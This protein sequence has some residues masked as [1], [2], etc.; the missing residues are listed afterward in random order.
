MRMCQLIVYVINSD[1]AISYNIE[2]KKVLLLLKIAWFER[3]TK[4]VIR[5]HNAHSLWYISRN[6]TYTYR[7]WIYK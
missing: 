7:A 2:N 1:S 3:R 4:D 6:L 5:R